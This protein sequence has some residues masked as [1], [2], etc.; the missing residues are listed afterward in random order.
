MSVR[1]YAAASLDDLLLL[2]NG[3]AVVV[4]SVTAASEDEEAEYLALRTA[5]ALDESKPVVVTAVVPSA[6]APIAPADIDALHVDVDN[7][8]SL[9]WFA[10]SE[11]V[12]VIGIL[13]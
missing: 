10:P 7:S 11:L 6:E 8:G 5:A 4:A 9:S 3:V 1:V 2:A 12:D 13:S